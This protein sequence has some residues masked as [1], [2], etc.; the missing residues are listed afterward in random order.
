MSCGCKQ[1]NERHGDERNITVGDIEAAAKAAGIDVQGVMM[2]FRE[3]FELVGAGSGGRGE[4]GR[5]GA[6]G[7][8]SENPRRR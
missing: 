1:P 7:L 8:Y 4:T 2:N 5:Q 3:D 6:G